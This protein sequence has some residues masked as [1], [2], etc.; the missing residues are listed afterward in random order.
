MDKVKLLLDADQLLIARVVLDI[1]CREDVYGETPWL[2]KSIAQGMALKLARRALEQRGTYRLTVPVCEA[3]M[4][5]RLV[6]GA[7]SAGMH[8]SLKPSARRLLAELD[9]KLTQYIHIK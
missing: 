7:L 6:L 4:L 5:R 3:I 1:Y 9:P 8:E 2:I